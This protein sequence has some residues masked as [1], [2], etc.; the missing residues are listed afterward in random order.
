MPTGLS[1]DIGLARIAG[2]WL[3]SSRLGKAD[4]IT[5]PSLADTTAK[6]KREGD[7]IASFWVMDVR[8]GGK[9]KQTNGFTVSEAFVDQ[10]Q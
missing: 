10:T 3:T 4:W 8:C 2:R 5:G 9:Q 7:P 6:A 1:S